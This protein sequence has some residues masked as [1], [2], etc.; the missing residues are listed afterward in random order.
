MNRNFVRVL[1]A[2]G[3]ALAAPAAVAQETTA[4]RGAVDG[5][6]DLQPVP[7]TTSLEIMPLA[8]MPTRRRNPDP[9]PDPPGLALGSFIAH[10]SLMVGSVYTSNVK[11]APSHPTDAVGLL[12]RPSLALESDWVRHRFTLNASGD[13]THYLGHGNLDVTTADV[14]SDL[15]LDVL[16][17]TTAN[18]TASYH[19][20]ETGP[21]SSEVP[22]SASGPARSHAIDGGADVTRDLGRFAVK[23]ST[24]MGVRLYDDVPLSGGGVED[25]G[26][27]N[28][29]APTAAL[30]LTYSDPPAIKPYGEVSYLPRYYFQSVDRYGN[31]RSSQGYG[32]ALGAAIDEGPIWTGDMALTYQWRDYQD[33]AL[34]DGGVLGVRGNLTWSP[35]ELTRIVFGIGTALD[36]NFSGGSTLGRSWT[37]NADVTQSVRDDLDLKAGAGLTLDRS[38]GA[39]DRTYEGRLGLDWSLGP[40]LA[41]SAGYN[42]TWLDAAASSRNYVEH[43]IETGITVR[44]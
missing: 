15:Q 19:L 2:A 7:G 27:R 36:D 3:L 37:F 43:R 17:G 44:R 9:A 23:L 6:S 28:Y 22:A 39:T 12:L 16:H 1:M 4:L 8:A 5:G 26:D 18:L 38:A 34:K 30:R 25:N 32:A 10:P 41:W 31:H 11:A 24:D 20:G 40:S 29:F 13:F 21:G 14:A 42:V 35:S 33:A